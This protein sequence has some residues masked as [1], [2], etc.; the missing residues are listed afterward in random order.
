M[1]AQMKM[2]RTAMFLLLSVVLTGC[3]AADTERRLSTATGTAASSDTAVMAADMEAEWKTAYQSFLN[4]QYKKRQAAIDKKYKRKSKSLNYSPHMYYFCRDIGD[5]EIPEL[6]VY[7]YED[8]VAV[9][10]RLKVYTY[11]GEVKEIGRRGM[12]GTTRL[13]Y[14]EDPSCPGIFT[15]G[16]GGGLEYYGYI[17]IRDGKYQEIDLW[18]EDYSG[19]SKELGKDRERIEETSSDQRLIRESKKVYKED[20]D[21]SIFK[22]KQKNYIHGDPPYDQTKLKELSIR[23]TEQKTLKKAE[24]KELDVKEEDAVVQQNNNRRNGNF[25][26]PWQDGYF[27]DAKTGKGE[28][29]HYVLTYQDGKGGTTV[30]E[31]LGLACF[32]YADNGYL[33]FYD[34]DNWELKRW[35]DGKTETVIELWYFWE[36]ERPVFFAEDVIYYADIDDNGDT[37]LC[38]TGYDG[39]QKQELY[40]VDAHFE[41]I[42]KY[43]DDLWFIY[44]DPA[45]KDDEQCCLGKICL[46]DD[47]MTTYPGICIPEYPEITAFNNGYIY[48]N[49]GGLKRINIEEGCLEKVFDKNVEAVNFADGSLLFCRGRSLYRMDSE[50][51]KEILTL[52][53]KEVDFAG[54]RVEDDQIYIG[55]ESDDVGKGDTISQIDRE[56]K[57]IKDIAR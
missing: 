31:E 51:V 8:D 23:Q 34:D 32:L 41:E 20:R 3:G 26:L 40:K 12:T 36:M 44:R 10:D 50:G 39:T 17:T 48:F 45:D 27:Y 14:S 54:I 57:T 22:V 25:V 52:K 9:E 4:E 7:D 5:T 35:K 18:N 33:Y 47:S 15:F 49:S 28:E 13:L 38:R 55:T 43:G 30:Q 16:V 11:R 6:F 29:T 2:I 56:G 42:Y 53:G 37:Y 46:A 21:I 24:V 19:I 1:R